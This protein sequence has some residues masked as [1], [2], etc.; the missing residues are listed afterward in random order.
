MQSG[1]YKYF[2]FLF[3]IFYILTRPQLIYLFLTKRIYLPVFPQFDQFKKHKIGTIVDIGSHKGH[4]AQT[5]NV[6]FPKA[7]I[8]AFEPNSDLNNIIKNKIPK[9]ILT[10]ENIALSN[11]GEFQNLYQA[12]NPLLTSIMPLSI[13]QIRDG[14]KIKTRV[15]KVKSSTL[16]IYFKNRKIINPVFLKIDTEG[17]EGLV[18]QGGKKFLKNVAVIYIEIY[19][20]KLYKNQMLFNDVYKLLTK[21]GFVYKGD[22]GE[23]YFYP[24]FSLE[25]VTN[26]VFINSKIIKN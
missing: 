12:E 8:Y 9:E 1:K 24:K 25:S 3:F 13:P 14:V 21:S 20:K 7:H 18:L 6:L 22:A 19:Y 10:L 11:K 4:M 26:S 2:N 15:K 23:A 17:A 5:L 16:D